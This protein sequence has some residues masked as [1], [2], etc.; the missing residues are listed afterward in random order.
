MYLCPNIGWQVLKYDA[1]IERY[2]NLNDRQRLRSAC[3]V[4]KII[5]N[6]SGVKNG[7]NAKDLI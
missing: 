2:S 7:K 4:F 5:S 6:L 3:P 1:F